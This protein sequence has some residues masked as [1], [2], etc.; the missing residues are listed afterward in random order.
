MEVPFGRLENGKQ[1]TLT[2]NHC[3]V[4]NKYI[5][6]ATKLTKTNHARTYFFTALT[7]R[8]YIACYSNL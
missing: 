8:Q 5:Q 2:A 4:V 7:A 6:R 1:F 3:S